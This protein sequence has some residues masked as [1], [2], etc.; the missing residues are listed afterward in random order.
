MQQDVQQP[1]DKPF[2]ENFDCRK[3]IDPEQPQNRTLSTDPYWWPVGDLKVLLDPLRWNNPIGYWSKEFDRA[4]FFG[5]GYLFKDPKVERGH[6][7]DFDP[8]AELFDS[9]PGKEIIIILL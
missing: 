9:G 2:M 3:I 5:K 4:C 8:Y 1:A 6:D 7:F